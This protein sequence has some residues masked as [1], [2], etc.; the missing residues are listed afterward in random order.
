M[1]IHLLT[2]PVGSLTSLSSGCLFFSACVAYISSRIHLQNR[3]AAVVWTLNKGLC[4]LFNQALPPLSEQRLFLEFPRGE[5]GQ[6]SNLGAEQRGVQQC[7]LWSLCW[8]S[9][10]WWF[11]PRRS[12][13]LQ[14]G[15]SEVT[16]Q[17]NAEKTFI[18]LTGLLLLPGNTLS[19]FQR[20]VSFGCFYLSSTDLPYN[21]WIEGIISS[22]LPIS[23]PACLVR[24]HCHSLSWCHYSC[25]LWPVA[26][27]LSAKGDEISLQCYPSLCL[28]YSGI[29]Q[30][31][32]SP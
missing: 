17:Q 12:C 21:S 3:R 11:C 30:R 10:C 25:D 2:L 6:E 16:R 13:L 26:G 27:W 9:C 32:V 5:G 19:T 1:G 24:S 4:L 14:K 8:V 7:Q 22:I 28:G 18:L 20:L 29:L 31:G 23:V 15:G